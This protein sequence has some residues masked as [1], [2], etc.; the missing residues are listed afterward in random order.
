MPDSR[1][2]DMHHAPLRY[3]LRRDGRRSRQA[4]HGGGELH[5]DQPLPPLLRAPEL[6][7]L[8]GLF[9]LLLISLSPRHDKGP[10]S[11]GAGPA[12]WHVIESPA[13]QLAPLRGPG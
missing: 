10:A 4:P 3:G 11:R 9:L 12:I 8:R 6:L 1:H 7:L 13:S 5:A 2:D